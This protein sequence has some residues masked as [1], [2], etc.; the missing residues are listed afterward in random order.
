M[1]VDGLLLLFSGIIRIVVALLP[2]VDINQPAL[3][4]FTDSVSWFSSISIH[5]PFVATLLA[6]ASLYVTIWG[7]WLTFRLATWTY[8]KLR[9]SG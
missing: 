8:D 3:Q 2:D 4:F 7:G 1:I 5:L 6:I 9:G